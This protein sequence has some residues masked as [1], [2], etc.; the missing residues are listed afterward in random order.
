MPVWIS[1][2]A[3]CTLVR[4]TP[5]HILQHTFN[6]TEL[7]RQVKRLQDHKRQWARLAVTEKVRLLED[8]RRLAARSDH[9]WVQISTGVKRVS[10]D[11]PLSGEEWASGPW[12][13]IS[14]INLQIETLQALAAGES[15]PLQ[16]GAVRGGPDGRVVVK[17]FPHNLYDRLLFS[18]Y[19]AEVWMESGVNAADVASTMARFY[20]EPAPEGAVGLVLGAA[21][22]TSIG[23]LDVL[24]KMFGEGEVCLLKMHPLIDD[25]GPVFET[26]FAPLIDAGY[27]AICYGGADVG[28]YLVRHDGID[29]IH[30]TGGEKTHDAI[31]YGGGAEGAERKR[32]HEPLTDKKVTSELGNVTPTIVVPG[33]W[34]DADIAYQAEHLATQKL[35]N[36]GFNCVASQVLVLP[37]SWDKSTALLDALTG[38]IEAL[39]ARHRYYP[40]VEDRQQGFVDAY[41]EAEHH[42]NGSPVT[43][44]KGLDWDSDEYCFRTEAFG[45]VYG[46]TSLPGASA[47]DYLEAAVEFCN[48]RLWGTLSA[49]III[50]PRTIKE[51]GPRFQTILG[52]LRYG[53]IGVNAWNGIGFLLGVTP[54]GGFPGATYDDIQSGIGT[55]H[56]TL[57]FDKAEK[58]VVYGPFQ[59]FPRALASGQFHMS[60]KPVWFVTNRRAHHIGRK[61]TGFV[62]DPGPRHLPGLFKHA[63]RG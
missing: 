50:H 30:V 57:L 61:I 27:A 15:P 51:L 5:E 34:S 25:L 21:N 19:S 36:S 6:S 35:H 40:G 1:P 22:I 24:S 33:P 62:A 47:A 55:V 20:R 26:I 12:A 8:V 56:N 14:T 23:P 49:D 59:P 43:V 4:A 60:P 63:L 48:D 9:D 10:L 38:T 28:E 37:A 54:W 29:T 39:P 11:S 13:L 32:R 2:E 52:R 18:G 46:Q 53:T 31:V 16:R 44:I 7:D 58:S 45:P 41:P 17:V 42:G 3:G